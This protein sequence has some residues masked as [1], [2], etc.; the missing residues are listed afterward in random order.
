MTP[1]ERARA[2]VGTSDV[3]PQEAW[4]DMCVVIAVAIRAAVEE[5]RAACAVVV[6]TTAV[7][8]VGHG[9]DEYEDGERTLASAAA[10][11]RR[12]GTR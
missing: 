2:V 7:V 9:Y 11:I 1:E 10:A 3:L 12:G 5:E 8:R 4:D 6:E